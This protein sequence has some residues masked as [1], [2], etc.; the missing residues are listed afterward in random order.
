MGYNYEVIGIPVESNDGRRKATHGIIFNQQEVSNPYEQT[1]QNAN[2][3]RFRTTHAN[4][5]K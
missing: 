4:K 1:N 3:A 5:I 2:I